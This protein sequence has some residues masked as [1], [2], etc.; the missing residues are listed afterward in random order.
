MIVYLI[1][2][3]LLM[4][5][6]FFGI[7]LVTFVLINLAPGSPIEQKLQAIRFGSAGGGGGGGAAGVNSRGDTSVNEEVIEALKKQYGFDKPLHERY[8][9]WL[10]N[11]SR[12]DFGESFTYQEPVIDVIK[13]KFPVSLQFGI[14]SLLLTYLVCIPLG[15]Q[16]AIKAGGAY[17]RITTL[18]LNFTY[19][20]PP[21]ILGI[22]LIVVLAGKLN[23]FPLGGLQS[24][25]YESF[26]TWGKITDRLHHF[27]LPLICYMIGGFTEL[28]VLMRNSMLD[29]IKSDFV[30]TARAKGLSER[31]VIFKHA[32]R[33]ALIPIAT[34]LGGFFGAF[35]AG[36][37][38]IEQM[39]NLDGIGLLGYQ[40]V[41]SR[42]YNVIMGLTFISSMLLMFGRIFSDIIYVLIDPRIDFK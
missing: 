22:F 9:I 32:L 37:L 28:S 15:V 40:S 35:L 7:T 41:L 20:I 3:L 10:K 16:K 19:S 24:D 42:D 14:A 23:L 8:F 26:T 29:V 27:V 34:G 1:R 17:D 11:L 21:L 25:D 13:S 2:R 39:F 18:I 38:I 4:I 31:I 33:N 5:P 6:T 36:S 30:R 12:L